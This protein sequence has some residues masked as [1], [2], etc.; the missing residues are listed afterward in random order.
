MTE[1]ELDDL[2]DEWHLNK[3][4]IP[5]YEYLG[6]TQEEYILFVKDPEEYLRKINETNRC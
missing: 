1:E 5:I 4:G 3:T 6:M 2:I